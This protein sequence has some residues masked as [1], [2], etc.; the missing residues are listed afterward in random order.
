MKA[1][2]NKFPMVAR[3]LCLLLALIMVGSVAYT[4]IY[5]LFLA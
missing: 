2:K 5:M 4:M 1:N 3:I